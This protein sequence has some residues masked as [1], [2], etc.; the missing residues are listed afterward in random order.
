MTPAGSLTT[1]YD[2]CSLANCS[3]GESPNGGPHSGDGWKSLRVDSEWRS[4]HRRLWHRMW[5]LYEITTPGK[6][7]TLHSFCTK[8][9]CTDGVGPAGNLVRATNGIFYG[10]TVNGGNT[11]CNFGCG[12]VFSLSTGLGPFIQ[13]VGPSG[14]VGAKVI[15][16][17]NGLSGA[18][19]V[20]FNGTAATFTIVSNTEITTTVPASATTG[21]VEVTTPSRTLKSNVKFRV[22][23]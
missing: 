14:P 13:T 22:S 18:T 15:I 21:T 7:T 20:R 11:V 10:I 23:S 16:L 8:S 9:N 5:N 1:L 6:L 2:F 3:D 4:G 19:S 17:G 12:T